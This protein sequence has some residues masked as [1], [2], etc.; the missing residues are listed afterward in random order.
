MAT[1][2]RTASIHKTIVMKP[3]TDLGVFNTSQETDWAYL[4]APGATV[5]LTS[6]YFK[7]NIQQC[8]LC[9]NKEY[10]PFYF[11]K[12]LAKYYAIS[13]IFGSSIPEEICNK[14]MHV[15]PPHLFTVLIP[16]LVKIMI[17]LSMFTLF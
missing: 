2:E 12:N 9:F 4:T 13:I 14:N 3:K 8:T 7:G 5:G 17:D 11:Y 16:H 1:T 15:Y 6:K 10:Y